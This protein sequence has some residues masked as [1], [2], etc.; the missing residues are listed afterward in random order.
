LNI[1]SNNIDLISKDTVKVNISNFNLVA[2]NNVIEVSKDG[3][4]DKLNI[5]ADEFTI[6]AADTVA[7][8][9]HIYGNTK[10]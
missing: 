6:G 4:I 7:K 3:I 8:N 1:N 5:N 2:N 10:T 9:L